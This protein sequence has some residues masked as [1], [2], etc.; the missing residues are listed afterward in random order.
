LGGGIDVEQAAFVI[1]I[2][3]SPDVVDGIGSDAFEVR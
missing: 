3:E 2:L 1:T